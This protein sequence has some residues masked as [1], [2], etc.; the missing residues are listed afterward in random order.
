M[1]VSQSC[2]ATHPM[3]LCYVRVVISTYRDG[4]RRMLLV[5]WHLCAA[6][7]KFRDRGSEFEILVDTLSDRTKARVNVER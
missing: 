3:I 1:S 6:A 2:Y 5:F 4:V 7:V